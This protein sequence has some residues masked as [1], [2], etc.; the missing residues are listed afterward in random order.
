M[1]VVRTVIRGEKEV[2]LLGPDVSV[3]GACP[4]EGEVP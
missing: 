4:P 2:P 3:G 1:A